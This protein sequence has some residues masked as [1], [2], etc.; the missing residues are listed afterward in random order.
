MKIGTVF[1]ETSTTEFVV[2]L[3]QQRD[4]EQLLFSYV[5]VAPDGGQP[6]PDRERIIARITNVYKEN[7][8]LSRDQAGFSATMGL[9]QLGFDF[10]KRF[11]YGWAK[12]SVVTSLNDGRLD[13]N[14]RGITP[15]AEVHTPSADTLRQVFFDSKPSFIPVGSIETFGEV[16]EVPVTMDADQM[17]TKHFC[18]FGMTGSGK[19]NSAAKVIEELMARGHRMVIFDSHDDYVNLEQFLNLPKDQDNNDLYFPASYD[20]VVNEAIAKLDPQKTPTDTRS[21]EEQVRERLIRIASV[22]YSNEPMRRFLAEDVNGSPSKQLSSALVEQIASSSPSISSPSIWHRLIAKPQ[23]CHHTVFPEI[24]Y[25]DSIGTDFTI[26]LL[27]AMQGEAFSPA[28][29]GWLRRAVSRDGVGDQYLDSLEQA[30]GAIQD[31][32]TKAAMERKIRTLKAVYRDAKNSGLKPLN[33]QAFFKDVASIKEGTP[34]TIHRLSMSDL[35]SSLRK[36]L[37]YG[38]VTYFFRMYKFGGNQ[39]RPRNTRP[40]NA[41]SVLFVLEE[42]R[43][44]IPKASGDDEGD[45]SGALARKA[46]RELAYEGRKFSLGYGI[47]SQKPSTVDPEVVSQCNTFILHQLKSPDDQSYVRSVTESMSQ[48]ELDMIKELGTGRAIVAGVA[49]KSPVLLRIDRRCSA[50]GIQEPT[51]IKDELSSIDQIRQN[52][53]I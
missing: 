27:E 1:G 15:N 52:L 41:Y 22:I 31:D 39:A 25:Y 23:V 35:S 18:I 8:L 34:E 33:F 13:M 3:D 30:A 2:M 40:R 38:V 14:R 51:P 24:K 4:G 21:L 48:E 12:C 19:T 36:A 46:M 32:K 9:D 50:D 17:V 26:R 43:S 49:V 16:S 7:P 47:I 20:T 29:W 42:A 53:E 37:V 10:S 6:Q 44:L 45:V 5:E 11:T 28:Q